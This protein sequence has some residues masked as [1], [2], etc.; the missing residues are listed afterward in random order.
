MQQPSVAT[1]SSTPQYV[2]RF[3][4][5]TDT[6]KNMGY[7]IFMWSNFVRAEGGSMTIDEH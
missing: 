5:G 6:Q 2:E 7:C 4:S 1:N 3:F